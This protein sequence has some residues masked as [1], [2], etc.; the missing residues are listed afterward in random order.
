MSIIFAMLLQAAS[1]A[2]AHLDA[3][4]ARSAEWKACTAREAKEMAARSREAADIIATAAI[5]SC[6]E[7]EG[8]MRSAAKRASIA[9]GQPGAIADGVIDRAM[10]QRRGELLAIIIKAR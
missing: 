7:Q 9:L 4:S 6:I 5:A 2:Q 3:M 1:G 8:A 10:E